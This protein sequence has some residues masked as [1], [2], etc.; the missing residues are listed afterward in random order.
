MCQ[1]A[2]RF[3]TKRQLLQL[4]LQFFYWI[5]STDVYYRKFLFKVL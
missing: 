3:V 5:H 1:W 4:Y 2:L